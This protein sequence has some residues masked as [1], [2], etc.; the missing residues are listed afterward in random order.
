V[1][2]KVRMIS[3]VALR[4]LPVPLPALETQQRIVHEASEERR[5]LAEYAEK[6]KAMR[7]RT[8]AALLNCAMAS[9][10]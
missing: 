7:N 10:A 1:G 8:A 3:Q 2:E 9:T 4:A 6:V 5:F